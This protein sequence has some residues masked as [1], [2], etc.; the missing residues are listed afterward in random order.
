MGREC[1]YDEKT[2][3]AYTILVGKPGS[4][5]RGR[6]TKSRDNNTKMD[7]RKYSARIGIGR[8]LRR[9]MSYSGIF[10]PRLGREANHSPPSNDEV[11]NEWSYTSTPPISLHR[12]VLS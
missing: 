9:I 2:T 6:Q 8:N 5:P 11:K 10:C 7:L 4:R 3:N 1:S 12:V